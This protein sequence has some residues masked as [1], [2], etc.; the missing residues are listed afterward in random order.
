MRTHNLRPALTVAQTE[1]RQLLA[2]AASGGG[3]LSAA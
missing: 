2:L 3:S 1:H